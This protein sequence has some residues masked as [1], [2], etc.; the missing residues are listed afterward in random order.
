ML[1][2][3]R[4]QTLAL[5]AALVRSSSRPHVASCRRPASAVAASGRR[6][7]AEY[8]D[9][10]V[11]VDDR[12]SAAAATAQ[13]S[14][15]SA[16]TADP[17]GWATAQ[18]HRAA[19]LWMVFE[20]QREERPLEGHMSGQRRKL[21]DNPTEIRLP[22]RDALSRAYATGRRKTATARV[23]VGPG[24][25]AFTVNGRALADYFPRI[26]DR[27]I[28]LQPLVVSHMCGA[29]DVKLTVRGSGLSGQAGACRHGLANAIA[30][31][32]PYMKPLLS[33]CECVLGGPCVLFA[34]W[35]H[36]LSV[37]WG[38]GGYPVEASVGH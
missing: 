7:P 25:G 4:R 9:G 1:P 8:E 5:V 12:E 31:Y 28:A 17:Y 11:L 30:R 21:R 23:W 33:R 20:A 16:L 29:V 6:A 37:L 15:P 38:V 26:G 3:A 24:S 10:D 2:S 18:D 27:Q 36:V 13:P 22:A 19:P 34:S 32:E 14:S 35:G